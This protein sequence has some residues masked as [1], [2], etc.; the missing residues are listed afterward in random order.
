MKHTTTALDCKSEVPEPLATAHRGTEK[1]G[2]GPYYN[3]IINITNVNV[4]FK[5]IL[6]YIFIIY[7]YLIIFYILYRCA[8]N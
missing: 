1:L 2:R 6:L 7:Q 5:I 4:L 8:I 3:N